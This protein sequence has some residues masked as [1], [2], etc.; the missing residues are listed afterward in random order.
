M[1]R[2]RPARPPDDNLQIHTLWF[3]LRAV[4]GAA[5]APTRGPFR[6]EL[7]LLRNAA[8]DAP[9]VGVVPLADLASCFATS[10][11][12]AVLHVALEPDEGVL[13]HVAS[14]MLS[15]F[16]FRRQGLVYG[17]DVLSNLAR[18]EYYLNQ[19]DLDIAARELNRGRE[20]PTER[21]A[22]RSEAATGDA[23]GV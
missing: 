10:V 21:L 14:H 5:D 9:D 2:A 18:P 13:S 16:T 23:S 4:H 1:P 3:S 7:R 15:A 6:D 19:K 8:L 11:T 12:P 20:G 17:D 22:R